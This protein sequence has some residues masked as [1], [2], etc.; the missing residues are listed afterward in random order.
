MPSIQTYYRKKP[1]QYISNLLGHE[2]DGSLHA[3]LNEKG[4][5]K[6]LSAGESEM[7]EG[8]SVMS[9]NISLTEAGSAHVDEISAYLFAYLDL[10]KDGPIERVDL[11]RA[12]SSCAAR[13]SF[14]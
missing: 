5:I 9:V 8:N 14:Q 6:G 12:G 13:F 1:V 11:P 3:R 2:G 10:L 4:W 7:D